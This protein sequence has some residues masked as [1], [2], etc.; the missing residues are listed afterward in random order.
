MHEKP[1][2]F[3]MEILV[4]MIHPPGVE[5]GSAALYTMHHIAFLKKVFGKISPVLA[6]NARYQGA[7]HLLGFLSVDQNLSFSF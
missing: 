7:F 2:P 3:L 1:H 4:N 5:G 6:G